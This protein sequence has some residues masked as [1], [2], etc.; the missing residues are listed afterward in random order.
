VQTEYKGSVVIPAH[1]EGNVIGRCLEALTIPDVETAAAYQFEI[2]VV[3]NGCTDET[4]AVALKFP[5]VTVIEIPESSKVAALNAGDSV[6]TAFPRI[7][8]DADSELSNHSAWNLLRKAAEHL[9]PA[10]FSAS[11]KSDMSGCSFLARSFARCAQRTSFGEFGIIGRGVY[12][13]NAVGRAR[14]QR[15]PQLI[16]DDFFVASL[17]D[18]DEQIID[19]CATVVVRPPGEVRSLVRVRS[20]IYYG[21]WQAGLERSRSVSPHHGWRNLAHAALQVSSVRDVFDVAVY[22]CVNFIAKRRAAQMIH[23]GLPAVWERDDNAR[24]RPCEFRKQSGI[25]DAR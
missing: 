9:G 25:S 18:A 22:A 17:F 11:V 6:V 2:V 16:G 14:F 8:L 23:Y 20:R 1:N 4:A 13:L 7:Y 24:T 15:F 5:R 3:C 19:P 21:N 12:T 10:I